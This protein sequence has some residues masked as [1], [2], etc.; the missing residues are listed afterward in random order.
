MRAFAAI[1]L[2]D[3]VREV[4]GS[5]QE[6]L[7]EKDWPVRWVGDQGLHLT[8]RFYGEVETDLLEP[9]NRSL[10]EAVTD[11]AP[12]PLELGGLG[13]FPHRRKPRVIWIGVD[14][15]PELE[16]LHH[17]VELAAVELGFPSERRETTYRPHV[18]LGRV[19]RGATLPTDAIDAIDSDTTSVTCLADRVL[20]YE[21]MLS[22]GGARYR[23]LGTFPIEGGVWAS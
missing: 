12:V 22:P 10:Q 18:T 21:S 11:T 9:L 2:P 19:K 3:D 17:R 4:I 6:R 15:P 7:R 23:S 14:A 1:P 5:M 13:V 8:I 16:L 20:L